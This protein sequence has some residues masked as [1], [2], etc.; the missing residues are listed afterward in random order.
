VLTED[1][2]KLI[3]GV[4]SE[5]ADAV[6][7]RPTFTTAAEVVARYEELVREKERR[8]NRAE[9]KTRKKPQ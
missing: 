1:E 3:A 5:V 6:G 9:K 8:N 7:L 4:R 2:A